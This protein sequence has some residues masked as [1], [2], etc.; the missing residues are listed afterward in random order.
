MIF[1]NVTKVVGA[2]PLT[3]LN[4]IAEGVTATI[5]AK[6]ESRNPLGSVKDR[7]GLSMIESAE[8]Q[9]LINADTMIIEPT[10]GNTGLALAF[11]CAARGYR[12]TL[13][14]PESMSV[15]RRKLLQHLGANLIGADIVE[16]SPPFDNGNTAALA[17]QL[18]Q[19]IIS[20]V[21]KK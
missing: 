9:G 7:I 6:I 1:S 19:I 8:A 18:I 2:T 5:L 21:M 15:E 13:T 10:S 14:M 11:V 17:S 12:L 4:R 16:V 3:R 20:Q